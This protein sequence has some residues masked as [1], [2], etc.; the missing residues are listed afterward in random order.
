MKSRNARSRLASDRC[1]R[2]NSHRLV[3]S[4]GALPRTDRQVFYTAPLASGSYPK[5][6]TAASFH[7]FCFEC[8]KLWAL[9][10]NCAV[11][12]DGAGSKTSALCS[13]CSSANTVRFIFENT[14]FPADVWYTRSSSQYPLLAEDGAAEASSVPVDARSGLPSP[15]TIALSRSRLAPA[16]WAVGV[17][18]LFHCRDCPAAP[19]RP[20]ERFL[21]RIRNSWG[22][23]VGTRSQS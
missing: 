22:P 4:S 5:R 6:S 14:C 9:L 19:S 7:V 18:R 21:R 3:R 17:R 16:R 8:V 10:S 23:A 13:S 1:V 11:V 2:H 15:T 20:A 12:D